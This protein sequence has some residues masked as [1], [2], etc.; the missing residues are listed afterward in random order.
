MYEP[1]ASPNPNQSFGQFEDIGT[2]F[3]AIDTSEANTDRQDMCDSGTDA[4]TENAVG[5]VEAVGPMGGE[6]E[7]LE[8]L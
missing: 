5:A 3:D 2:T 8:P 7:L 4:V 6:L 1:E